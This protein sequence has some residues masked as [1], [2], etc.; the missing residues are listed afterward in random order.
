MA[1]EGIR[2]GEQ[3]RGHADAERH[4]SVRN[5]RPEQ[6][7]TALTCGT[8]AA[9]DSQKVENWVGAILDQ[10]GKSRPSG[11]PLTQLHNPLRKKALG[12]LVEVEAGGISVPQSGCPGEEQSCEVQ[13]PGHPGRNP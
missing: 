7:K 10:H 4:F 13:P 1:P 3:G 12:Y 5:A 9:L 8:K 2:P 11:Y 6:S